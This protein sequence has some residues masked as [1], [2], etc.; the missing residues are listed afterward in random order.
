MK[1]CGRSLA[2]ILLAL[3]A[4]VSSQFA[5]ANLKATVDRGRVAMGDSL[6][7]TITTD[8][9]ADLGDLDLGELQRD[10]DLLQRS[11]SSNM[12][13]ANGQRS[14]VRQLLLD[15]A[16]RRQGSLM[17]PPF[18]LGGETTRP[19]SVVVDP[20]PAAG[21]P[22][23]TVQF[24]AELDR[25]SVYVQGQLIL[26]LRLQFAIPLESP[27]ITELR[28]DN[29]F[30]K[31]LG[32]N[33][34]NRNAAGRAWKV[35]E[36]RYAIFPEQS[37]QLSIPAQTF[38]AREGGPRRSLF[39]P[40]T[41]RRLQRSSPE[42]TVEVLPRPSDWP[43]TTWLPARELR[44]EE[45]WSVPPENLRAGE[46]ATRTVRLIGEGLQGAQLPPVLFPSTEGLK[47]YPD[48]PVIEDRES[49]GG[50]TGLRQDSAALVPTRAGLW[51]IPELRIPWWDTETEAIRYA[52]LP[53]RDIEVAVAPGELSGNP[54]VPIT[55][56]AAPAPD[57]T[58]EP[59]AIVT[60]DAG[61]WPMIAALAGLGWL[62]TLAWALHM[63]KRGP[64]S[65]PDT[66]REN[67]S[68]PRLFKQLIA[69][70]TTGNARHARRDLVAWCAA[71]YPDRNVHSL[72]QVQALFADPELD[73]QLTA[74]DATLYGPQ[75]G[76][77]EGTE[78]TGTLIRL[79]SNTRAG[80]EDRDELRLYP[81][82]GLA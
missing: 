46:S 78:L 77:W 45:Q 25:E 81:E 12:T 67:K 30:V 21:D 72:E 42:L 80:S 61:P 71:R 76:D 35:H 56:Q 58:G 8:G 44:L 41:G 33:S 74:L 24:T 64:L 26:T 75:T 37:G 34:Y 38:T 2:P 73:T 11:T 1:K 4:T 68:E 19:I 13:I 22:N 52:V 18:R 53:A 5:L 3:L 54:P 27:G 32:Q 9:E 69:A 40:G 43:S 79:R 28:L 29:A 51:T 10:F 55:S 17:I 49:R 57:L 47:Y 70:C 23:Q 66:T 20:A 14:H 31:Q 50:L 63:R 59:L 39:N 16:P 6:R 15:I 82:G 60:R 7:L 62:L 65:Q 36:I 48:Q